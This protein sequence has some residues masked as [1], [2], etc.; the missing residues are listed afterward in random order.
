MIVSALSITGKTKKYF[1]ILF[2]FLLLFSKFSV[3]TSTIDHGFFDSS[4]SANSA[5][6]SLFGQ[7]CDHFWKGRDPNNG[8]RFYEGFRIF[9]GCELVPGGV[10]DNPNQPDTCSTVHIFG[11]INGCPLGGQPDPLAGYACTSSDGKQNGPS[12][13]PSSD[14][15]NPIN[16]VTGNKHQ[17]VVD[18]VS[19]GINPLRV[20]RYYNSNTGRWRFF[21][22][23][24]ASRRHVEVMVTRADGKQL[25]FTRNGSTWFPDPDVQGSVKRA[26]ADGSISG[27]KYLIDGKTTEEYNR[28]G[29]L[30]AV[31]N[32]NGNSQTYTYSTSTI[33]V[34]NGIDQLV[35]DVDN[36]GRI[37]GFTAGQG[38]HYSY[39]YDSVGRLV[40]IVYPNSAVARTYHYE[41]ASYP[42]ALT[43]ITDENGARFA[44]WAY[45][46]E[47]RAISSEHHGSTEKVTLDYTHI[48][49]SVDPRVTATNALGKQTTY[50][51]TTIHGVRKVTQVEGHQSV[52]CAAA[53]KTYTYDTNGFLASK[54]DWL[55]NLI[56]YT[57]DTK[58]QELSRTEAAGTPDERV[59]TTEWHPTLNLPT[60]ITSSDYELIYSYDSG[61]NLLSTQRN[62]LTP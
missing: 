60:K 9:S 46:S 56:S 7:R 15:G 1:W 40:S 30:V 41:N 14:I 2:P 42:N 16:L 55:G 20:V 47:G 13:C 35:F 53:N 17:R 4:E 27:W 10:A 45:D 24:V 37:I 43:G 11:Y 57:R 8:R 48:D 61:G 44:T 34:S 49:D 3:A 31:H 39:T 25:I 36:S 26:F 54:T 58:G 52:H 23:A 28:S 62:D 50:H 12:S 29:Q 19:S 38:E 33:S 21:P 18:Y 22:E 51:F 5:C 59:F 32:V 6:Q